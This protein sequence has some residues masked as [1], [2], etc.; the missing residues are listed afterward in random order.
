MRILH[1][2]D[3][4]IGHRLHEHDRFVEH[5]HFLDWLL[6]TIE[7]NRI[8]LLVVAGDIFDTGHPSHLAQEQYYNFLINLRNTC[9]TQVIIIGGNHDLPGTLNAPRQLLKQLNIH[10]VGKANDSIDDEVLSVTGRS[11]KVEA[12]V[13]AV[14]YLR[15]RDI[16][17]AIAG[18]TFAEIDER[19]K[20]GIIRRYQKLAAT[21]SVQS[22]LKEAIP[23]LATG[24]L[25]AAGGVVQEVERERSEK[26]I[27]LGRFGHIN[28]DSF[29][30]EFAYIALGHLHR[31][32]KVNGKDHIRYAG[33]PLPL[34]F[35]EY[36]DDKKVLMLLFESNILAGIE[37][38]AVPC[39]RRL[40]RFKG[41][42]ES[43]Q[44]Q[45]EKVIVQPNE[46]NVWA[47][48]QIELDEFNPNATELI[49]DMVKGRQMDVLKIQ[50]LYSFL[51]LSLED[52]FGSAKSL[53]EILPDDVFR[54]K[55]EAK[56]FNLEENPEVLTAFKELL[57]ELDEDE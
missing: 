25:Y 34:S 29:P 5:Q 45:I 20:S 35:S 49:R 33:S 47:E 7:S 54:S 8:D 23:V 17:H 42:F 53:D 28:G 6:H 27:H 1:T 41:S 51:P 37:E 13:C 46:L 19:I 56:E 24:H 43:I 21:Q 50:A 22:G 26:E 32:Q 3:W 40:N 30:T 44:S 48:I 39:W 31:P 18:E 38:M 4:H 10:I 55:C 15:D 57:S 14:P 36:T 2:S 52:Q 16:R 11:G 12:L 9:C